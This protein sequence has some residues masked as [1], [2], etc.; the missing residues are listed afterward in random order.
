MN[1]LYS[2]D[3]GI[4]EGIIMSAL[5]LARYSHPLN[6]YILTSFYKMKGIDSDFALRL[7]EKL[8]EKNPENRVTLIDVTEEFKKNFP[9]KNSRT[10]FTPACMLRLF[11]D[12]IPSLPD[13]ILYLD[14]DVICTAPPH[15]TLDMAGVE[16]AGVLDR[17]GKYFFRRFPFK[18]S[19]MNSG[20]L[21]LNLDEIRKTGLFERCRERCKKKKMFMPDQSA[22]N[23]EVKR[24]I[25]LPR[26]FNEQKSV[27]EDTV[28]RHFTTCFSL[29][30]KISVKPWQIE[31]MHSVLKEYRFDDLY[32]ELKESQKEI[33]K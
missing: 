21:F 11:A 26:R 5:S 18:M 30:G 31:K 24:K 28:F 20:V 19:Y 15:I 9:V 12:K 13:E 2:G 7:E 16:V 3:S 17:Y 27:R 23:R 25:L 14:A 8:K 22:I 4:R 29:R 1:I 10:R 32:S 33:M 6:I